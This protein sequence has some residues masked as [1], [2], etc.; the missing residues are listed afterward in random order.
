MARWKVI[1]GIENGRRAYLRIHTP[2][3]PTV[4]FVTHKTIFAAPATLQTP[5]RLIH[6]AGPL[7]AT[8][9]DVQHLGTLKEHRAG[10]KELVRAE[11]TGGHSATTLAEIESINARGERK[12]IAVLTRDARRADR[13]VGT[14]TLLKEYHPNL[15]LRAPN[16]PLRTLHSS[17]EFYVYSRRRYRLKKSATRKITTKY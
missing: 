4:R 14:W 2:R 9:S 12:T 6:L 17:R 11:S 8:Q 7:I 1:L 3:Q 5:L 16:P 10:N 15:E 13:S